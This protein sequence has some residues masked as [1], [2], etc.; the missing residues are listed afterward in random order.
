[1]THVLWRSVLTA[2][3][4]VWFLG[5]ATDTPQAADKAKPKAGAKTSEVEE[6]VLAV[7]NRMATV[8]VN[9]PP[10]Y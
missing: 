5:T 1:M 2:A 8:V 6:K 10:G 7:F 9:A 4:A 3:L